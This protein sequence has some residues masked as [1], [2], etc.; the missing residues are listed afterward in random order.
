M[1][2]E[3]EVSTPIE[4]NPDLKIIWPKGRQIKKRLPKFGL[5]RPIRQL[6]HGPA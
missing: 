1:K 4:T 6:P 3:N 2:Q 5:N